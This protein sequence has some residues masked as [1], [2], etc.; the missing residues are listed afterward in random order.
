MVLAPSSPKQLM[1]KF[2][3]IKIHQNSG[4][5]S[6]NYY[7]EYVNEKY[8]PIYNKISDLIT[9]LSY[10]KERNLLALSVREFAQRAIFP[11]IPFSWKW[12]G[13]LRRKARAPRY[14]ISGNN[15]RSAPRYIRGIT[16]RDKIFRVPF[17]TRKRISKGRNEWGQNEGV[18]RNGRLKPE[19]NKGIIPEI[20]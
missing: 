12:C 11:P 1:G 2:R 8:S 15:W 17:G 4:E 13:R 6:Q 14:T 3:K 18:I 20:K 10:K 19:I 9:S 5:I 7:I 16:K